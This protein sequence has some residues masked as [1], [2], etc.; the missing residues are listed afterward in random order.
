MN[1]AIFLWI[2]QVSMIQENESDLNFF[3]TCG[4]IKFK[5]IRKC[6]LK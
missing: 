4:I 6:L 2:G 3:F 5:Y 1:I